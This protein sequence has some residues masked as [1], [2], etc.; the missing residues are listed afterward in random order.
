MSTLRNAAQQALDEHL[1]DDD[2]TCTRCGFDG[3]EWAWWRTTYE[4][5]ALP[6]L[7]MPPCRERAHG[8]GG[9]A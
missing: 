7:R 3:A 2:G 4:G 8:I 5:K 1:F 9:G 6:H